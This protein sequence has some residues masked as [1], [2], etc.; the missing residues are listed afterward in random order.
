MVA[1]ITR[2]LG[3]QSGAATMNHLKETDR[4]I[5]GGRYDGKAINAHSERNY[6]DP[7]GRLYT[8]SRDLEAEGRPFQ[9]FGPFA[10]D[11]VGILPPFKVGGFEY[12]ADWKSWK[13]AEKMF[14]D[15]VGIHNEA[16][17]KRD[18]VVLFD[19]DGDSKSV[20]QDGLS[21]TRV[22]MWFISK[23]VIE[24]GTWGPEVSGPGWYW[25]RMDS[26]D[27][28]GPF[29]SV[30]TAMEDCKTTR[31]WEQARE[32]ETPSGMAP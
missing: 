17:K 26:T 1:L 19:V 28:H 25:Q 6:V 10:Q 29:K 4:E 20:L 24:R 9:A 31:H 15:A 16:L 2:K 8:L 3:Y 32:L 21:G 27:L 18:L 13:S 5:Y 7:H 14:D 30:P 22:E 12:F 23:E 11:F